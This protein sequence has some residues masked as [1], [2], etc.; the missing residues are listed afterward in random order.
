MSDDDEVI[1]FLRIEGELRHQSHSGQDSS[2]PLSKDYELVGLVGEV[3]FSHMFGLPVNWHRNPGGDGR[4][5]F[6]IPLGFTVDVKCARQAIHLIE[7]V[8]KVTADI[9]V[10]AQYNEVNTSAT[11]L[12]WEWG[13][14]LRAAPHKDFG[15]GIVNHY[16]HKDNL[17]PMSWLTNR[18]ARVQCAVKP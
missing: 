12:G 10:L 1:Q 6:V 17:R 7:E 5:D 13:S 8:G 16:I 11:L 14:T 3:A 9:Y 15:Y 4:I 2:R 18:I